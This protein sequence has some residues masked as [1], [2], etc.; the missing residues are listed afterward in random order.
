M[1]HKPRVLIS[2]Y[3]HDAA[4]DYLRGHSE[5]HYDPTLY[6]DPAR[7]EQSLHNV[8][9]LMVR[10]QSQV[11]AALIANSELTVVGRVGVGLDNLDLPALKEA[12]IVVT[13][14]PGTNAVSVAEY[15]LGV[16]LELSRRFREISAQLQQGRWERQAAIGY[17]LYGK[18]LG[19]IG[20]GD[21]GSR[22]ARRAEVL[23]MRVIANDPIVHESS[24]AVQEFG[25]M[26]QDFASVLRQADFLSLHLPLLPSSY[27]L[28]NAESLALLQP[29]A[30][31]INT[32]RGGLIDEQAL[33]TALRQKQ[34]AAAVLD[35]RQNE[36]PGEADPLRGLDNL[37]LTPHIAGVTHE[38]N[39][40]ASMHVAKD[41]VRVLRGEKALSVV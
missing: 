40:R 7:L 34:L 3:V 12:G 10:N 2:E 9:A 14:A 28:I 36:P 24:L 6:R 15:V 35:V 31:L 29:H 20:L 37:I 18:T 39:Q 21:I 38:S 5:V 32:S 4:V 26:Q 30:V 25:I 27:N 41:I 19:I 1:S 22:L 17:E 13:W 23:G 16:M 8:Q 11:N 33:A